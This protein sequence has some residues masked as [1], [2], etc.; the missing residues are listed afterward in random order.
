ML[1]EAGPIFIDSFPKLGAVEED[2][3]VYR[4]HTRL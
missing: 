4:V 2:V 1:R 3:H